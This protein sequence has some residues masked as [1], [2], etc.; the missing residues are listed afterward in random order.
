MKPGNLYYFINLFHFINYHH[1]QTRLWNNLLRYGVVFL[2][3]CISVDREHNF[4][5]S[6]FL[7]ISSI[8]FQDFF[9]HKS[10]FLTNKVV[11]ALEKK[12]GVV[13]LLWFYGDVF[14]VPNVTDISIHILQTV[15][16]IFPRVLTGTTCLAVKSFLSKWPLSIF[17]RPLS[18]I[19]RG[20]RKGKLDA[21][22]S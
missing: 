14:L 8:S 15:V 11:L 22:H 3:N 10:I 21:S 2:F 19:P 16:Y 18:L 5:V 17:L 12:I 6:L 1:G 9:G 7:I 4:I 20:S 13:L